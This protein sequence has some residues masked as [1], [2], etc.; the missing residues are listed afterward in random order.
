MT[1][2]EIDWR[3]AKYIAWLTV[4]LVPS[5]PDQSQYMEE[6]DRIVR[7]ADAMRRAPQLSTI[8]APVEA[9]A[10]SGTARRV[11]H[12]DVIT[13]FCRGGPPAAPAASDEFAALSRPALAGRVQNELQGAVA[14]NG[15][16]LARA[17]EEIESAGARLGLRSR[18]RTWLSIAGLWASIGIVVT[19]LIEGLVLFAR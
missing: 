2:N 16:E 1:A 6:I 4:V 11:A 9:S 19:G 8:D 10:C 17:V 3:E 14:I 18:I 15:D 7:A 5:Q 12:L 13:T